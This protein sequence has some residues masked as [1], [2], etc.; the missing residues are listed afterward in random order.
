MT[1]NRLLAILLPLAL[2]APSTAPAQSKAEWE[3][4]QKRVAELEER[5]GE[6]EKS[7]ETS[8]TNRIKLSESLTELRLGGDLRLRYQ[9]DNR[10][11]QVDPPGQG[12]D[13]DRS[14]SSNQRSRWRFRL[15]LNADFKL[16]PDF[17]GGVQLV[18]SQEA[19]SDNQTFENGFNDYGI[20]ISR[21]YLGWNANDWLTIVAGKQPNPLYSTEVVWDADI[22]PNGLSEAIRFHDMLAT[23]QGGKAW[24]LTLN[25][26]QFIYDDNYEGAFDND[27]ANDAY[28]FAGQLVGAYQ[29]STDVRVTF[30]PGY[31]FFNAA[32]VTGVLAANAFTDTDV[33][34]ETRKLSILTAPGDVAFKLGKLPAKFYWDFAYNTAGEGRSEDIYEVE[35]DHEVVDDIAWLV[36][37]QL[38]RNKR[39]GDWSINANWRQTGISSV[40]PNLNESD[41]AFS[42]L[43]TRGFKI[44]LFYSFTDFLNA[45]VT[46]MHAWNLRDNLVG[47]QATRDAA[48][49]DANS[50]DIFQVDVNLKF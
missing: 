7:A 40:D 50:T 39:A 41:F 12:D 44:S 30:A 2:L 34:G 19:D 4:L 22:N 48:V 6:S 9:A 29:L 43:N 28:L 27:D 3:A 13:E 42:E 21:A 1:K 45:G 46:Y 49:A 37:L 23:S 24:E 5:L 10:D 18:T 15:R 36:G 11:N 20:Y 8:A 32:E 33:S 47:G 26:G 17:F 38:G 14:P 25:L 31:L 35:T 16:G